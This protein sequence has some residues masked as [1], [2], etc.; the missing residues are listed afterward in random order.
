MD[1]QLIIKDLQNSKNPISCL[2]KK[3]ERVKNAVDQCFLSNSCKN[4]L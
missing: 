4:N 3:I 1:L 2:S